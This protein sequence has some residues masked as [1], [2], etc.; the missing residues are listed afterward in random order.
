[1]IE[2]K[3][4]SGKLNQDDSIYSLPPNDYIDALNITHDAVAGGGDQDITNVVANRIGDDS[5]IYPDGTNRCIGAHANT[6]RNTIIQFIWN[7]RFNHLI[8]EYNLTTRVQTKIFENLTDSGNVDILGFTQGGKILSI[9]IYNRD[10]GDLLF[11]LDSLGRP[12]G[13]DIA[14][15]KQGEYTPV[16]RSILDK[17]KRPPLSPPLVVYDNE[18]TFIGNN[19]RN[20]LM[21]FRYRWI[22]DDLEKSTFS[23]ISI[24]PLPESIISDIFTNVITNN[25][26]IR[27]I[28]QSGD[29]NVKSVELAMSFAENTNIWSDFQSID[30]LEKS[31]LVLTQNTD[32]TLNASLFFDEAYIT[33][34]GTVTEGTEVNI[35]LTQLPSTQVLVATYTAVSGDTLSDVVDGLFASLTTLGLVPIYIKNSNNLLLSY[36]NVVYVFGEVEIIP[37]SSDNDNIAFQY[38]FYNDSTYP[39]IPIEESIELYDYVPRRANAQAMPNGD[40][41]AYI[42]LLE[43]YNKDTVKSSE[44]TVL[45]TAAGNGAVGS[46]NGLVT[47]AQT[48]ATI[49]VSRILFSGTPATG[50][51]I[52]IRL[53]NIT[54]NV[55]TVVATYTTVPGDTI[56][57]AS[58]GVIG[59]LI[60][61]ALALGFVDNA[62]NPSLNTLSITYQAE[63]SSSSPHYYSDYTDLV[64]IAPTASIVNN[65]IASWKWS[66]SRSIARAYFDDKG[67]TNGIL[68]TDKITFPAYAEDGSNVPLVPYIN[69]KINDVPPI[70]AYSVQFYMTKESTQW[71]FWESLSVNKSEAEYIYFDVSSFTVNA[72]KKP[73]TAK[74]LSYTFKDGDRM[75]VIRN[76]DVPGIVYDNTYDSAVEGL[77]IDP[78]INSLPST[79]QFIKIKN[80]EPFTSG[81]D[82]T[83]N[84]VIELYTPVQ[85]TSNANNQVY[86]EFGQQYNILDPTLDTRRH[87]G[88]VSNQ[89]VGVT[90][91]EYNF[92][93]GDAYFRSRTIA[94]R[95]AGYATFNVMDRNFVDFYISAVNSVDGRPNKID[96]DAREAYYSTL[97]RHSESYQ[98]NTNINGLNRFY[99]KN[100]D[101]YDYSF[102]D[103][104]AMR[105]K[106]RQLIIFQKFKIGN[107]PLF[108][109]IG[110]DANGAQVTFQTDKLLNPIQYYAGDFGIGTCPES[111]A[112]FNYAIYGCDNIK[113]VIWRLS[114]DGISALSIIYKMNTWANEYLSQ[115][116]SDYK[117]YGAFDQRLNNYIIALSTD[118]TVCASVFVPPVTLPDGY[119]GQYY[120]YSLVIYG[121]QPFTMTNVV[122]P[123]W[124]TVEV[125]DDTIY[126]TGMPD[127]FQD[128]IPVSFD[129]ANACGADSISTT[130]NILEMVT[131]T[132]DMW[133]GLPASVPSG[134]LICDGSAVNRT[135]YAALFT[136]I[137]TLYGVGDGST[138]FNL[139]NLKERIPAGYDSTVTDYNTVGKIGGAGT[140]TLT[141][142]Q[143]AHKHTYL[144]YTFGAGGVQGDGGPTDFGYPPVDTSSIGNAAIA[145]D[146]VD[147]RD[148]FIVLPFKIKT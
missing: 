64:I 7:S 12:T 79:G 11:F 125:V 49:A 139:P 110:K 27:L 40:T 10:E 90:P 89:V 30:V 76:T 2:V 34:L 97:I 87:S 53:K 124:M 47:F 140:A 81:I 106:N 42:G 37:V 134:W 117:V 52:S 72:T 61:S 70:W 132:I 136:A 88:M 62:Q 113:G 67:V 71:I 108:N 48:P 28:I 14:L 15:F 21:R 13:L 107:V 82:A 4:F 33:F 78:I 43:G 69:Y 146:P 50:T 3:N 5:F 19:F 93:E 6:L 118:D 54:T 9:D 17:A 41:L 22:Y 135:T 137:G 111:I 148:K 96:L 95:E 80:I 145:R 121:T 46:L 101:E 85:Q 91:A 102:G 119:V 115:K 131:G 36:S 44:V 138:T 92:Y 127:E 122:A 77:V 24:V 23:P 133:G 68:Y 142:Q 29:K 105:I 128:D 116:Y 8:L 84:Y 120:S 143:I 141:D 94:T 144:S 86:Y 31:S 65:S 109:S 51:V 114:N 74:V 73:T 39:T 20:K 83:K 103:A 98:A 99:Y 129:I 45:T 66:T 16:T 130:L 126:F 147:T 18:T 112:S 75:R 123:S 59:G 32:I 63:A 35:Y 57:N 100:S 56:G 104:L 60:T 38:S 55:I 1:M 58:S 25:N 26:V